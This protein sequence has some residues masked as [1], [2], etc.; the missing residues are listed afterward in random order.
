MYVYHPV[1]YYHDY[2]YYN[3]GYYG[4][5]HH[6]YGHSRPAS[7]LS[8][9][10]SICIILCIIGCLIAAGGCEDSGRRDD[11]DDGYVVHTEVHHVYGDDYGPPPDVPY[12]QPPYDGYGEPPRYN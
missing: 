7:P 12:D 1:G 10:F 4:Y 9:L 5:H 2:G 6:Y 11:G 3:Y 8:T